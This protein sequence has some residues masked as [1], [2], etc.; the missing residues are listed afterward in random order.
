MARIN[1]QSLITE[2]EE[3]HNSLYIKYMKEN[4]AEGKCPW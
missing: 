4:G 1:Y 2:T 3:K